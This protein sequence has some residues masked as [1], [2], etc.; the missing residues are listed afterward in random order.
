MKK[1]EEFS[2]ANV[3]HSAYVTR[4]HSVNCHRHPSIAEHS[5]LVAMYAR[6]L[7][8]VINPKMTN[9]DKLL[10][11]DLCLLHDLPEVRTGDMATPMKRYL[12]SMFPKGQSP[13]DIMEEKLCAPYAAIREETNGTYI[14]II[15]KLADIMEAINFIHTEGKG[16]VAEKIF[17]ER[18]AAFKD[19]L[20]IG[21]NKWPE[22][23]WEDANFVMESLLNE[24][25]EQIDFQEILESN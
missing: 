3:A 19:Y 4:W 24:A 13:I 2:I 9:E 17:I 10:L 1:L 7:G 18:S 11:T 12:E 21:F 6:Y 20:K 5:F 23:L 16:P 22:Y 15:A 14:Q 8:T 25:P